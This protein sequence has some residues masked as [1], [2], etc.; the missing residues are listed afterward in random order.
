VLGLEPGLE[1][2]QLLKLA[3][4]MEAMEGR[5]QVGGGQW[6]APWFTSPEEGLA[7]A[8][9]LVDRRYRYGRAGL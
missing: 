4:E 6:A 8:P 9:A 1:V 3:L 2:E 5:W 7:V